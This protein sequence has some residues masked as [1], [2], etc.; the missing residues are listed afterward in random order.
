MEK[1]AQSVGT[2]DVL[3]LNAGYL[4]TPAHIAKAPL[5]D[6]WKNYEVHFMQM[7]NL[8]EITC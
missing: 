6:Y 8:S 4:S 7:T 3:I 1:A 5:D 2:W